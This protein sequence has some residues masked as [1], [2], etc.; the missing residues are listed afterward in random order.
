MQLNKLLIIIDPSC[1]TQQTAL[2]RGAWLAKQTG[3]QLEL[4]ICDYHSAL[5]NHLFNDHTVQHKARAALLAEHLNYLESLAKPLREQGLNISTQVRWGKVLFQEIIAH[6]QANSFD[7]VLRNAT[8]HALLQRML[9]NNTSWQLIR[10]C[11]IP[12]W[13]VQ[14]NA[15]QNQGIVAALDPINTEQSTLAQRIISATKTL[16]EATHSPAHYVHSYNILP[17]L[18]IFEAELMIS[19]D[20][21]LKSLAEA[22]E[23]AFDSLLS[24]QEIA[25]TQRKLLTGAPEQSISQFVREQEADLLVLGSTIKN[26]VENALLGNTAERLLESVACDLLIIK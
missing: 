22:H 23:Q 10:H 6:I 5:E 19:Y 13:L 20:D 1:K 21:Y 3:A 8:Q 9:F 11:P 24:Q 7:L 17:T 16:S 4:L 12:L 18:F 25:K 15:W 26:A 14:D 2:T